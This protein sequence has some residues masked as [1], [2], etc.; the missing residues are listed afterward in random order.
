MLVSLL[1]LLLNIL[2]C[3]TIL[4]AGLLSGDL[5]FEPFLSLII[6]SLSYL[7]SEL[8]YLGEGILCV[9]VKIVLVVSMSALSLESSCNLAFFLFIFDNFFDWLLFLY[10]Q[11]LFPLLV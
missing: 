6:I 9:R 11:I 10:V 1:Q 4:K 8:L 7:L 2:L 3:S 5:V